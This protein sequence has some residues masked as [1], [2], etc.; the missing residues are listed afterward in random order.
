MNISKNYYENIDVENERLLKYISTSETKINDLSSFLSDIYSNCL[1]IYKSATKKLSSF[2]DESNISDVT[3]KTDQNMT[4]FYQ[5][6]SIFL[7]NFSDIMEKFNHI[8][9]TPLNNFKI[10][11]IKENNDIKNDFLLLLKDYKNEKKKLIAYQKKY[12]NSTINYVNLKNN[13]HNLKNNKNKEVQCEKCWKDME[14]KRWT[15]RN[16]RLLYKYQVGAVNIYY[17]NYDLRYKKY[18]KSF[19]KNERNKLIFLYNTFRI[20]SLKIKELTESLND[21]SRQINTKF[22]GWKI[23][24]DNN[25]IKDEFNYIG[26]YINSENVYNDSN[27]IQRFNK[28]VFMPYNMVNMNYINNFYSKNLN[29]KNSRSNDSLLEINIKEDSSKNFVLLENIKSKEYQNKIIN[30]FY[31]Y[32]YSNDE[33][34]YNIISKIIEISLHDIEFCYRFIKHYYSEHKNKYMHINKDK[35][36][37]HFCMILLNI[38][39]NIRDKKDEKDNDIKHKIIIKILKI[40]EL[41]YYVSINKN[42]KQNIFLSGLL[43]KYIEFKN[44]SFWENLLYF[45][46]KKKLRKIYDTIDKCKMNEK[47]YKL[48]ILINKDDMFLSL[49]NIK[50]NIINNK[51]RL[52]NEEKISNIETND[53][54]NEEKKDNNLSKVS[55]SIKTK[56]NNEVILLDE[57]KDIYL[58]NAFHKFHLILLEFI[59][60]L[61]NY[62][63]GVNNSK[64]LINKVCQE[65]N[66]NNDLK[67]YYLSYLN[68]FSYSI[69]QY[70]HFFNHEINKKIEEFKINNNIKRNTQITNKKIKKLVLNEKEKEI[71]ILNISKYL[72]NNQKIKLI[73]LNKSIKDKIY[74]K[75][76][77]EILYYSDKDKV[78]NRNYKIHLEIWK[79]FLDY[80]DIKKKYPYDISKKKIP[81]KKPLINYEQTDFYIIDLDCQRTLF[82]NSSN[83][84]ANYRTMSGTSIKEQINKNK[85]IDNI[86]N[87]HQ[88]LIEMKRMSLSNILKT[89][90]TLN[91]EPT[92]C[93]GM[94]FIGVFLLKMLNE[95]EDDAF[96]FMMGLFKCTTYPQIFHDNLY[97]LTLYFKIFDRILL[98][99]IPTLYNYFK[100]NNVI[101]NYYLSSCFITLFTNYANKEKK[102]T[103]FIKIFD[104]FIIEEWTGI[105]N[106]IL[107]ILWRNEDKLLSLKNENLLHFLNGN[108]MNDFLLNYNQYNCFELY[109]K[110]K[111]SKKLIINIENQLMNSQKLGISFD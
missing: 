44:N 10:N 76:Y 14:E 103:L 19:E 70:S 106:I 24:E 111:I 25:I 92:Y 60:F 42:K 46:I 58:Q 90:I 109:T 63:F 100:S 93:Q 1:N 2:F 6:S 59:Q 32:F 17:K 95:R 97:K 64:L 21:L 87:Y 31:R 83:L 68:S 99:F 56:E 12:Y 74:K 102:M 108:L 96:Y 105:F 52:S 84:L 80:K 75:I 91:S 98:I 30:E 85:M 18:Y 89:L 54:E 22:N 48:N 66:I 94:N 88:K 45:Q 104:L 50:T 73:R 39:M 15:M 47:K 57:I 5:T 4:F 8:I 27:T 81:S 77:K 37:K 49:L 40:G 34:T 9:I 82:E 35:N 62:N 67:N 16:N 71:I 53:E 36:V 55:N 51:E 41:I 79:Y 3:T 26:R 78:K 23:E 61:D 11:Y 65:F 13:Y 107:E 28:E 72:N 43:N 69:K 101:P 110:Q 7:E 20:F 29:S 33:I 38:L 86:N